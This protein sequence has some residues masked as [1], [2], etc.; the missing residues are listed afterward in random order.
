[1]KQSRWIPHSPFGLL[2]RCSEGIGRNRSRLAGL[3]SR[4]NTASHR[5]VFGPGTGRSPSAR[6][7]KTGAPQVFSLTHPFFKEVEHGKAT[8]PRRFCI[9]MSLRWHYP[10]QVK[11]SERLLPLSPKAPLFS[12]KYYCIFAKDCQE[13]LQRAGK[14]R[15]ILSSKKGES[16]GAG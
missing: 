16:A 8:G 6:S 3:L 4:R 10:H 13:G 1:M 5:C 11:G 9:A 7:R 15:M 2:N 12:A 14:E